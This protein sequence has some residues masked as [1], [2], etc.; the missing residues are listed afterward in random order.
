M[1]ESRLK[2]GGGGREEERKDLKGG[3][4]IDNI[5]NNSVNVELAG[6]VRMHPVLHRASSPYRRIW[7]FMKGNTTKTA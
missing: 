6:L 3:P 2:N 4:N 1:K 5:E 7:R